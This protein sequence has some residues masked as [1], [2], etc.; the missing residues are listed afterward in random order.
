MFG[1]R[2]KLM[3]GFGGLL[4]ILFAGGALSLVALNRYS[5]TLETILRENYDSV[6]YG[7]QMREA[8][9]GLDDVAQFALFG[10]MGM[11]NRSP[12][13]L[14]RQYEDALAR[15]KRNVTLAGEGEFVE[16]LAELWGGDNGY[17]QQL[18][19]LLD[20]SE[21][22][23]RRRQKYH[24]ALLPRML[25]IKVAAQQ[26]IDLNVRNMGFTN[27]GVKRSARQARLTI[28]GLLAAGGLLG[29]M[30][31]VLIGRSILHQIGA[32]TAS[33]Q[34]IERGNL[35]L[36]V[37]VSS[38]DEVGRLAESFNAMAARLRELRR[39]DRAKL[40]RTQRTTS[41]ALGSLPDAVAII[42]PDGRIE[43]ANQTAQKLFNL[44]PETPL[45]DAPE[46]KLTD[47]FQRAAAERRTIQAKGYDAAI[48]IFD[49]NER[50]FIPSAVPILDEER[51]LTGVTL[52]LADVTN[53]RKIDEMKSGL[54]SVVSHE[55][56]TPLTS[57]RMAA[58]LLLDER[59]GTLTPKQQ[60]LLVAAKEDADRLYAIIENLLDIGRI[61]SGK[62][63]FDQKPTSP[64]A[65]VRDALAAASAAFHDKGV[66]LSVNVPDDCPRV[67]AD[68]DRVAHVFSNLLGNALKYTPAGGQVRVTAEPGERAVAF[69]VSDTGSGIPEGALPRIFERFY[70]APEQPNG[71]KGAGL[72]LA[73]AKEIVEAHG[74]TIDVASSQGNG[75]QFT[76]TLPRGD[77][78]ASSMNARDATVMPL[79]QSLRG[80]P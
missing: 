77:V 3:L 48:Q 38:R 29:V 78:G 65:M 8:A 4:A 5:T 60:E 12:S 50:F 2:Q 34:E 59:V 6:V 31:V 26:V 68:A 80:E 41:L 71:A 69:V 25:E 55:L 61:E 15:E 18:T 14:V 36:I 52:V 30:V 70:R 40:I 22:L 79:S 11:V 49:G 53:L 67:L 62:A 42:S 7:Q 23:D 66:T 72:G 24:D 46:I 35:D 76:F 45:A 47:L 20:S 56:K 54:L 27:A 17:K 1:I 16:R 9:E 13:E 75:S 39:T 73:I 33:A 32:V 58:H 64:D 57:I 19:G 10:D 28:Y 44:R 74:G 37:P 43:I 21:S 63:L 51:N